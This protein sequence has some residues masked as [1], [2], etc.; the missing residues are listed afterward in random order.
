MVVGD[1]RLD[2]NTCGYVTFHGPNSELNV[3]PGSLNLTNGW[4]NVA[5]AGGDAFG[6]HTE[7]CGVLVKTNAVGVF[8]RAGP[9]KSLNVKPGSLNRTPGWLKV[10]LTSRY[11]RVHF[12]HAYRTSAIW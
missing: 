5:R 7:I 3:Y 9:E 10:I 1:G 6:G 11:P 2:T 8:R 12:S 4:L